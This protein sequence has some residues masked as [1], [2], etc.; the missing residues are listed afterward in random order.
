M[1]YEIVPNEG[2]ESHD[3]VYL[4]VNPASFKNEPTKASAFI[5]GVNHTGSGVKNYGLQGV[6]LRQGTNRTVTAPELNVASLR[7]SDTYA[8]LFGEAVADDAPKLNVTKKSLVLGNVYV[9]DEYS[10][11]IVVTGSNLTG[12]ISVESSS[13]AVT[14]S[15]ATLSKAD[16]MSGD[17]ATLNVHVAYTEGNQK[18]TLTLKSDGAKDVVINVSWEGFK[19]T[20]ISS[21]KALYSEDVE[22]YLTY[23]YSGEATVTYVDK[24]GSHP[25]Y[26]L[27]DATGAIIGC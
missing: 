2:Y 6:E 5:D 18:A 3:N 1:R 23:R 9:G 16:V 27:Q 7:V 14:V 13:P 17:G 22:S 8:G 24:G 20:D 12:D 11:D 15:P 4:Y 21:L 26:Y 25:T 19:P 10:G